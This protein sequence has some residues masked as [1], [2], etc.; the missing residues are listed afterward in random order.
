MVQIY[1]DFS[2][3]K[4]KRESKTPMQGDPIR[5]PD[6]LYVPPVPPANEKISTPKAML[7]SGWFSNAM[8]FMRSNWQTVVIILLGFNA[9]GPKIVYPVK[10]AW[11]YIFPSQLV[12]DGQNFSIDLSDT[13]SDAAMAYR[14]T[15]LATGS[16]PKSEDAL[17]SHF[18]TARQAEFAKKYAAHFN[19]IVPPGEDPADSDTKIKCADAWEE[20]AVGLKRRKLFKG[21]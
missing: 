10:S 14:N 2:V 3:Y 7:I 9:F 13:A 5:I 4:N 17:E 1:Y 16:K 12:R 18:A 21:F 8:S 6:P 20:F 11:S 15:M 19:A